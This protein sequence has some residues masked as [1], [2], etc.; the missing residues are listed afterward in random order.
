MRETLIIANSYD[1]KILFN[2][3]MAHG[4]VDY[5]RAKDWPRYRKS[6]RANFPIL[7]FS[8]YQ[9]S[10]LL[11]V[12]FKAPIIPIGAPHLHLKDYLE[13]SDRLKLRNTDNENRILYFPLHSHAGIAN[14]P[15]KSFEL[16]FNGVEN[17][18]ITVCLYWL[19]FINPAI[20]KKF[21]SLGFK[22]ECIG[23]KGGNRFESPWSEAGSRESFIARLLHLLSNSSK[24]VT[25]TPDITFL[26]AATLSR[27]VMYI[28]TSSTYLNNSNPNKRMRQNFSP[29]YVDLLGR[30][31]NL[32]WHNCADEASELKLLAADLLGANSIHNFDAWVKE[33]PTAVTHSAIS[34]HLVSNLK[35]TL[36]GLFPLSNRNSI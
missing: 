5:R 7:C 36:D 32:V 28:R 8:E 4:D 9:R 27:E 35:K 33:S 19:D 29:T 34:D 12:G 11:D 20:R 15:S 10:K 23:Y 31:T 26:L 1:P 21:E 25:D 16:I 13:K 30:F 18:E 3:Q 2:G 17:F 6:I 24:V 14:D 22:I